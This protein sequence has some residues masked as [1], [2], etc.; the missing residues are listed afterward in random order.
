MQGRPCCSP[1]GSG[2]AFPPKPGKGAVGRSWSKR[3]KN[4][5]T[6]ILE[7]RFRERHDS[8]PQIFKGL[9]HKREVKLTQCTPGD[10]TELRDQKS[11]GDSLSWREKRAL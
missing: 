7:N 2:E 8:P 5:S 1:E 3:E 11:Q 10:R 9:P 4:L 6:F